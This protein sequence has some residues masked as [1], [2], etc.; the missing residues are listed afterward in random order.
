MQ[1]Q[2]SRFYHC[3]LALFHGY[4]PRSKKQTNKT[5][6]GSQESPAISNISTWDGTQ[7][8]LRGQRATWGTDLS[9]TSIKASDLGRQAPPVRFPSVQLWA[10]HLNAGFL[11]QTLKLLQVSGG[12]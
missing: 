6:L 1:E 11:I 8:F 2:F 7:V 5:N 4:Q 9:T 10:S 3:G 12:E